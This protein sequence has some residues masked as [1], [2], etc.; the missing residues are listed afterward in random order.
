MLGVGPFGDLS[1]PAKVQMV[2]FI[3]VF[4]FICI[5]V[6]GTLY[7]LRRGMGQMGVSKSLQFIVAL[8]ILTLPVILVSWA[9]LWGVNKL[10]KGG[11][12]TLGW[13][14]VLV[15][16]GLFA[17]GAI[18]LYKEI[19]FGSKSAFDA[20]FGPVMFLLAMYGRVV[21]SKLFGV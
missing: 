3:I 17:A 19:G 14:L 1:G 12:D 2:L 18:G 6:L 15:T 16:N 11:K 4:I 20:V 5:S 21:A 13:I 10:V 9:V 8:V 7:Y